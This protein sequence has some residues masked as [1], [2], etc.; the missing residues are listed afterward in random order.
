MAVGPVHH[1]RHAKA[2]CEAGAGRKYGGL[3]HSPCVRAGRPLDNMFS[4][5]SYGRTEQIMN[6][7]GE[8]I[9]NATS[10]LKEASALLG[11]FFTLYLWS[12]L[13]FAL[14]A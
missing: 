1:R 14:Q 8:A 12:V 3:Q 13:A 5:C 7:Y 6:E 2:V 10:F 4:I 11:L 9:M